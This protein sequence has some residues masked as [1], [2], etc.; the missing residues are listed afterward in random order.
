MSSAVA[1]C[2]VVVSRT[3]A[4]ETRGIAVRDVSY[5]EPRGK[6][7]AVLAL[8]RDF[9]PDTVDL[10]R[11]STAGI[12]VFGGHEHAQV[13]A[14]QLIGSVAE[15]AA[16]GVVEGLHPATMVDDDDGV[17]R[18]SHERLSFMRKHCPQYGGARQAREYAISLTS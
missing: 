13:L 9:T 10:T 16:R 11:L 8:R 5:R 12:Q 17:D 4:D 1:W 3:H 15:D 2:S 7:A 14:E 6:D 18:G